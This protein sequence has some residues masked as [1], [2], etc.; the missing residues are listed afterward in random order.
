[1]KNLKER[2]EIFKKHKPEFLDILGFEDFS[3]D[4][5]IEL[6][7]NIDVLPHTWASKYICVPLDIMFI[8]IFYL[9]SPGDICTK[10]EITA[11][12]AAFDGRLLRQF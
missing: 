10:D 3:F 2:M 5:K 4:E 9:G 7:V 12:S 8:Y 1:M 11:K 6:P